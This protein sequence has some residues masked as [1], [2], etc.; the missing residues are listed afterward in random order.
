MSL[1]RGGSAPEPG[2]DHPAVGAGD[3]G[4]EGEPLAARP[5]VVR[6]C[7]Q[8]PGPAA[9][10]FG[11]AGER[12]AGRPTVGEHDR[13]AGWDCSGSRAGGYPEV[14]KRGAGR[15]ESGGDG[16]RP[17]APRRGFVTG[18]RG[19]GG[20]ARA[21]DSERSWPLWRAVGRAHAM[22]RGLTAVCRA[23]TLGAALALL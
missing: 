3:L 11:L 5:E 19:G 17:Q 14:R 8:L 21:A 23:A 9:Q 7:P 2:A 22:L 12:A 15:G 18:W 10:D 1:G 6:A 16:E 4:P 20:M 13:P